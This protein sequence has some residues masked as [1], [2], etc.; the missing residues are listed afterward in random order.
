LP[1]ALASSRAPA[2][3]SAG[4]VASVERVTRETRIAAT[5]DLDGTGQYDVSTGI[6][7]LSTT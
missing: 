3:R 6:G 1:K 5:V 4:R 2:K 7:F